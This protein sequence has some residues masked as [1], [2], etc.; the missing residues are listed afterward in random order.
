MKLKLLFFVLL[1][2]IA[3]TKAQTVVKIEQVNG[4]LVIPSKINNFELNVV[5]DTART[6]ISI[7]LA[8][9]AEMLKN[10]FL[11]EKDFA[12]PINAGGEINLGIIEIGGHFVYNT[13][14]IIDEKQTTEL[15]IGKNILEQLGKINIDIASSS[16]TITDTEIY[17][18]DYKITYGCAS[19]NCLNGYGAYLYPGGAV[20]IGDF[21]EGDLMGYGTYLYEDGTKYIGY[22]VGG[23]YEGKG[24]L[25]NPDGSKYVGEFVD[26]EFNGFG[27]MTFANG[28]KYV[29][30]F[31]D[32]VFNGYGVFTFVSGQ[33]Y[34]GDF[35]DGQY[36][37]KGTMIFA[38]GQKYVG[39]FANNKRNG[40]G[41]LTMPDG[42][43]K[44]GTFKN[45]EYVGQ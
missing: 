37:G 7:S 21:K 38:N 8:T 44:T 28:Q 1:G 42:T 10:G 43:E 20:Y 23:D 11:Y 35:V 40:K 17:K 4:N 30:E 45:G 12:G 3:N 14:A 32:G 27:R 29:G 6:G 24:V 25:I 41:T 18:N 39:E 36:N 16:F 2:F 9:A 19:G 13:K 34:S 31:V 22:F 15:N 26:G 33:K 5:P